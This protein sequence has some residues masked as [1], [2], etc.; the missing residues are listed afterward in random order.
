[1]KR[2]L[3]F[4]LIL[5]FLLLISSSSFGLTSVNA[6][7]DE[8]SVEIRLIIQVHR[9]DTSTKLAEIK[10]LVDI[11]NF[12]L[13]ES[14]VELRICGGG[15]LTV[16]ASQRCQSGSG[17]EYFGESEVAVWLL[18]GS[19]ELFPFDIYTLSF[20]ILRIGTF[21]NNWAFKPE[22]HEAYFDGNQTYILKDLWDTDNALLPL[23]RESKE[24]TVGLQRSIESA[25]IS[26]LK[27]ITPIIA[28]YY[29][30]G[31]SLILNPKNLAERL[32]IYVAVFF[33]VP[34]YLLTIQGILPYRNY[35]SLPEFLL[36]NLLIST[37]ILC[38]FGA[39]AKRRLSDLPKLGYLY[40]E[41]HNPRTWDMLGIVIA[42]LCFA[43]LYISSFLYVTNASSSALI[44]YVIL[45]AY[46]FWSLFIGLKPFQIREH[47]KTISIFISSI[48]LITFAYLILYFILPF[49]YFLAS[50][51]FSSTAIGFY[52]GFIIKKNVRG[53]AFI[54][55]IIGSLISG[56]LI[57]YFFGENFFGVSG[58]DGAISGFT[59]FSIWGYV[60]GVYEAVGAILCSWLVSKYKNNRD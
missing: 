17:W 50:T 23:R 30:M 37:A 24:I 10:V 49:N 5:V 20:K 42:S 11:Y 9:V 31:A 4:L 57:G 36:V 43:I 48:I 22:G 25:F 33:F 21:E 2:N 12:P 40:S 18:Q 32:R 47:K 15:S 29:L 1:M 27:V 60:V 45:P 13:N 56:L 51:T 19:G 38:I 16:N 35:L 34:A 3:R 8:N 7:E 14:N 39:V 44:S 53:L 28:C 26:F 41:K 52:L 46:A 58:L 59:L 55:G 6:Q 54:S